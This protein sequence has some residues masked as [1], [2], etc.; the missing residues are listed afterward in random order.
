MMKNPLAVFYLILFPLLF[1]AA[2]CGSQSE[3]PATTVRDSAEFIVAKDGSGDFTTIGAALAQ[4]QPGDVIQVKNGIYV[5]GIDITRSGTSSEPI[6]LINYPGHS[7]VIDPGGGA[8]PSECCTLN[9]PPRRVEVRAEWIIIEG[10]EIRHGWDGV[11]FLKSHNTIRNNWI[12]H[13]RYQGVLL[14]SVND[15]LIEGNTIEY[16]GTDP[17]ACYD[18]A[19]GGESPRHCHAVYLSDYSCTGLANVTISGNILRNQGGRGITWNG[20]GCVSKSTNTVVDSN[21]IENNSWGMAVYYNVEGAK[22][23]NNVFINNSRPDTNDVDWTFIGIWGSSGNTIT[24]NEFHTVMP[25][26][27]AIQVYDNKSKENDVNNNVWRTAGTLWI[28]G[29]ERRTDWENYPGISGW[30]VDS[31]I[32][33][34]CE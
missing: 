10:F 13:N 34:G 32:C 26:V 24:N 27:A 18:R 33:I 22:I 28:W 8:Y 21:M 30:D 15:I 2:G 1:V 11:K 23:T 9:G 6:T 31:D 7:P 17:G 20:L 4:S 25:E 14:I 3:S 29:G 16:N 19:W 5:E 12:H